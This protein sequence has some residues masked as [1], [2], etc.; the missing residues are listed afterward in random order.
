MEYGSAGQRDAASLA[1]SQPCSLPAQNEVDEMSHA[2]TDNIPYGSSQP[3]N[4]GGAYQHTRIDFLPHASSVDSISNS[5]QSYRNTD[6][7]FQYG[8]PCV[9]SISTSSTASHVSESGTP[10]ADVESSEDE[11]LSGV[12][13]IGVTDSGTTVTSNHRIREVHTRT[14]PV[15]IP[16]GVKECDCAGQRDDDTASLA[17]SQPCSLP[18]RNEADG[19][20][21][22]STDNIPYGSSQP[23]NNGGAYRNI[24]FGFLL[25]A[26]SVDSISHSYR[27][28]RRTDAGSHVSE[29]GTPPAVE[30]SEC[31][32]LSGV[33]FTGVADS[34][35]TVTSDQGAAGESESTLQA[36]T[37][38]RTPGNG[39]A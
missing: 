6:V 14:G 12:V 29:N 28:Y 26:S 2:S 4:N 20:S 18:V 38:I 34:G 22:A 9:S 13:S 33:V 31:E 35:T 21:H 1:S 5:D 17:S 19:M 36:S 10:S 32:Q 25:Y 30:S 37:C 39:C 7:G 27:L 8:G 3:Q 24:R 11:Q 23:Q 15:D 16:E